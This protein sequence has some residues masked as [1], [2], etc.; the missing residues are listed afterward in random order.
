MQLELG[1]TYMTRNGHFYTTKYYA[2]GDD[3]VMVGYREDWDNYTGVTR[4]LVATGEN[5]HPWHGGHVI[6][7]PELDLIMEDSPEARVIAAN[8][9]LARKVKA[10]NEA[11]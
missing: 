7:D 4:W 10:F 2:T 5:Y 3:T 8:M 1:K 11:I 6:K 9:L